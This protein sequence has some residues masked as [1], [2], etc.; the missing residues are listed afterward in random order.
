MHERVDGLLHDKSRLIVS[1]G[2]SAWRSNRH[3]TRPH[4]TLR[5]MAKATGVA[6]STVQGIWKAHGLHPHR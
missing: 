1:P 6:A 3:R 2:S 5:A 4:W